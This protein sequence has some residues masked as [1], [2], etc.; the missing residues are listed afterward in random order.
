MK[1]DAHNHPKIYQL[2]AR[3][4]VSRPT[5]LGHLDL[6]WGFVEDRA[7]QGDIG[8]WPNIAIA[9]ACDWEGDPDLFI[10]AFL[11][12]QLLDED[13]KHRLVVHDWPEHCQNW[14]RAKLK[15][16]NLDFIRTYSTGLKKPLK[17]ELKKP[18][19]ST[20]EASQADLGST[21]D[22]TTAPA[23]TPYLDSSKEES[24]VPNESGREES[25]AKAFHRLVELWNGI[26][27]VIHCREE[28]AKRKA[29]FAVRFKNLKWRNSV[30][31]AI[32]L[33]SVSSFCQG[34]GN[35]GWKA[36][37]DWFLKP[38]TVTKIL[39]GKF[40]DFE[41]EADLPIT[42]PVKYLDMPRPSNATN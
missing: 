3:L 39:E 20:L 17:S 40:I 29:A 5:A 13:K 38:D 31:E 16:L 33:V 8:K 15:K 18:L 19:G 32:R 9:R 41:T 2:A 7:I 25:S 4:G 26:G 36:D 21:L 34:G 28:T 1:K 37:I 12:S 10:N 42:P 35:R 6:L 30:K 11:D 23:P 22:A 14:V 24:F 27:G